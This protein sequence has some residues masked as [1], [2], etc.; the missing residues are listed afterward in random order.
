MKV[1]RAL[2]APLG[3]ML[4]QRFI[5]RI[6]IEERHCFPTARFC[7][8]NRQELDRDNRVPVADGGVLA[9]GG[10]ILAE[11]NYE[12][13]SSREM[14]LR[15]RDSML[16]IIVEPR[17]VTLPSPVGRGS[18]PCAAHGSQSEQRSGFAKT[19]FQPEVGVARIAYR[20]LRIIAEIGQRVAELVGKLK[21]I[22]RPV[23]IFSRQAN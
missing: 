19:L 9:Q 17:S 7:F 16:D 14:M 18:Q 23:S 5:R 15:Q 10:L 21:A 11:P 8:K 13:R 20:L 4:C 12:W 2:G 3:K 1:L 6:A 22:L